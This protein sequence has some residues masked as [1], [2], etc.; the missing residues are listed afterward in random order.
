MMAVTLISFTAVDFNW[1]EMYEK[2]NP[3]PDD[4]NSVR[5]KCSSS[6]GRA[7]R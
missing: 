7:I 2:Y 4:A 1:G 3:Y 6:G 5:S